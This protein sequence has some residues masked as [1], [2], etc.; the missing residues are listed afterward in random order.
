MVSDPVF[1]DCS[2][3]EEDY[4]DW[5]QALDGQGRLPGETE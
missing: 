1:S 2:V 3:P 5:V 4:S